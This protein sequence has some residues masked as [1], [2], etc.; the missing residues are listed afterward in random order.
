MIFLILINPLL[1]ESHY[2]L[3]GI[4]GDKPLVEEVMVKAWNFLI[5]WLS[6]TG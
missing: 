4:R 1:V 6:Y 5:I 3:F 2:S